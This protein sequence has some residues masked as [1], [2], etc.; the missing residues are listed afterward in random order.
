MEIEYCQS[1]QCFRKTDVGYRRRRARQQQGVDAGDDRR[2]IGI[3]A[4]K[5]ASGETRT[6]A[7]LCAVT[8]TDPTS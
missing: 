1:T 2:P 6:M 8:G 4:A 3:G 5:A 7:Q